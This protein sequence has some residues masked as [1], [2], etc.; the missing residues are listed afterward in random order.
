MES[1]KP[2]ESSWRPRRVLLC[3]GRRHRERNV[4]LPVFFLFL[5]H[6]FVSLSRPTRLSPPAYRVLPLYHSAAQKA[7]AAEVLRKNPNPLDKKEEFSSVIRFEFSLVWCIMKSGRIDAEA[8]SAS[9]WKRLPLGGKSILSLFFPSAL[10]KSFSL[11]MSCFA[12]AHRRKG[13]IF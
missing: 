8:I 11:P 6:R 4:F 3:L 13:G 2:V 9:F 5:S 12:S 1:A 10:S 7:S